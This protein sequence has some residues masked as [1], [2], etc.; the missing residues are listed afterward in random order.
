MPT[1]ARNDRSAARGFTL[2]EMLMTLAVLSLASLIAATA[3]HAGSSR[4][5]VDRAAD[6]LLNDLKQIRLRAEMRGEK[7]AFVGSPDG[8]RAEAAGVAREFPKGVAARWNNQ[9]EKN[10]SFPIGPGDGGVEIRLTKNDF[11]A[12]IVV[13][14]VTGSIARVR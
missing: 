3:F 6:A 7:F 13:A 5:A 2:A 14:P 11:A 9:P 12:I 1:S 8:Y 10:W 4:L